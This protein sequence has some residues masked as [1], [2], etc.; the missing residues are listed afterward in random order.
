MEIKL[1][2]RNRA[3]FA[4]LLAFCFDASAGFVEADFTFIV[5]TESILAKTDETI[6]FD[7]SLTN[8]SSVE[9][10][11]GD[12][13]KLV[14]AGIGDLTIDGESCFISPFCV[15]PKFEDALQS[16]SPGVIIGPGESLEF[17]FYSVKLSEET[18]DGAI[19]NFFQAR[20]F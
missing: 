5:S 9:V 15:D 13:L 7:V 4:I 6:T 18:P 19:L 20:L 1:F 10:E 8:N 2:R 12:N 14:S 11:L 17:E 3:V 16:L